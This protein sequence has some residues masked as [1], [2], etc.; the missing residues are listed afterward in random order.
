MYTNQ[1]LW[2]MAREKLD[3]TTIILNNG[4][5][6]ILNIELMRVGVQNPG[7]KALSMLDLKNPG[8]QLDAR[9]PKAWACPPCGWKRLRSFPR[10]AGRGA[11]P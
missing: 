3:V 6:A 9:C 8:D 4:S 7:P 1:A 11:R 10:R 5:Y 2:T